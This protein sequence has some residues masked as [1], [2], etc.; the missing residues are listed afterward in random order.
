V[1]VF[2]ARLFFNVLLF[3]L[4]RFAIFFA[5]MRIDS[6]RCLLRRLPM[7]QDA[8]HTPFNSTRRTCHLGCHPSKYYP[9]VGQRCLT[10]V[11]KWVPVCPTCQDAVILDVPFISS[12][13][14][15]DRFV[16]VNL[17]TLRSFFLRSVAKSLPNRSG[18]P[19]RI[20]FLYG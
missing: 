2:D 14:F 16:F 11:I 6:S 5:D 13:S 18:K 15:I 7:L 9:G 1:R 20:K 17:S 10:L 19:K 8:G 12:L 4:M 3:F